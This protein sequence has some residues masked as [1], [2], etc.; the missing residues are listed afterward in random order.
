MH[1][2][3]HEGVSKSLRIE[4]ITKYT[5]TTIN[6]RWEGTQK[7]MAP[8]LTTVTHKIAIQLHL[9]AETCTICS[10]RFMQPV[11]KLLDTPSYIS[12][13][14][15]LR[16][17]AELKF[18]AVTLSTFVV[19]AF[20]FLIE[21]RFDPGKGVE[22]AQWYSTGIRAGWSMV[23]VPA[24]AG[25]FSLHHRVQN[26]TGAHPVSYPMGIRGSFLGLK[27]PGR[28]A[29]HSPHVVPRSRI[30]GAITPLSNT[31]SWRGA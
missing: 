15:P 20:T 30:R 29:D 5:L 8:K 6:T 24:R 31:P 9:L 17:Q 4:S 23:R 27:R 14:I 26:G 10:S 1:V 12:C 28:E 2:T 7:V 13:R 19:R 3:V 25:N 21:T 18:E 11:R 22:I 16:C